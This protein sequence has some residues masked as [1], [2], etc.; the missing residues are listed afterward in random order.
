MEALT[1]A[2]TS[3]QHLARADRSKPQNCNPLPPS[4]RR[5]H[6]QKGTQLQPLLVSPDET[7]GSKVYSHVRHK[8]SCESRAHLLLLPACSQ[9]SMR[10]I[11]GPASSETQSAQLTCDGIHNVV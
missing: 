7:R 6:F 10:D 3:N 11:Q 8:Y 5:H 9:A 2:T 4:P 1:V